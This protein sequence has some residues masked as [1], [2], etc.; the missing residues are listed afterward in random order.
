MRHAPVHARMTLVLCA[1][2]LMGGCRTL[3]E[4]SADAQ[5]LV[6]TELFFGL[7]RKGAPDV[8]EQE[9]RDFVDR[10]ITPRFPNGLTLLDAHGQWRGEDGN[11]VREPSRVLILLHPPGDDAES[12]IEQVRRLYRERFAQEAVLRTDTMQRVSF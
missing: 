3:P 7:G 2:L 5:T 1:A 8:S 12:K 6:R 11:V 10:E 9:W 4:A